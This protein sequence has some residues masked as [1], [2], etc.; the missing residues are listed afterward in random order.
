MSNMWD[1]LKD[2]KPMESLKSDNMTPDNITPEKI[3]QYVEAMKAVPYLPVDIQPDITA[4]IQSD[5]M[6]SMSKD[7]RKHME[8]YQERSNKEQIVIIKK[9]RAMGFSEIAAE[10]GIRFSRDCIIIEDPRAP[11]YPG[12]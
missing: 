1:K 7:L 5:F 11:L 2:A 6:Q 8:E 10:K 12:E 9:E 3:K 4:Q